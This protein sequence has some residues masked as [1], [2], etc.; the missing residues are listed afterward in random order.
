MVQ[1]WF[2]FQGRSIFIANALVTSAF[3][4][5]LEE[6]RRHF[7]AQCVLVGHHSEICD[8]PVTLLMKSCTRM[9]PP[10]P[11]RSPSFVGHFWL[12][13][14]AGKTLCHKQYNNICQESLWNLSHELSKPKWT[15]GSE[16]HYLQGLT[17]SPITF[18]FLFFYID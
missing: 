4:V 1:L 2:H 18:E 3:Q 12:S 14:C 6:Q 8:A 5:L 10:L 9:D 16:V 17:F 13:H 7:S 11:L 15:L